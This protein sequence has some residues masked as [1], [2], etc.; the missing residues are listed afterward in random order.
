MTRLFPV[1]IALLLATVFL[2]GETLAQQ[3]QPSSA[4]PSGSAQP[5]APSDASG[6][7]GKTVEGKVKS[8]DAATNMVTLDDGIQYSIPA[9]LQ[10]DRDLLLKE[11]ASVK[12]SYDEKDGQRVILK[13]EAN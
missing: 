7:D 12:A 11:G 1:L 9:D 5:A 4:P 6:K 3:Q 13:I 10:F 8:Y 2:A